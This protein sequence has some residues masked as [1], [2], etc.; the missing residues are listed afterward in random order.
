[1]PPENPSRVVGTAAQKVSRAA[2]SFWVRLLRS[3][4][5]QDANDGLVASSLAVFAQSA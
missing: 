5:S 4:S 1:M 2:I 3:V